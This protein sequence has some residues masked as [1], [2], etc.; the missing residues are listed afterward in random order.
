M[1]VCVLLRH[2][3]SSANEAGVLAGWAPGIGLT[4]T[5]MEQARQVGHQLVGVAL[6]EI[7]TSPVQRAVET[8]RGVA[9]MLTGVALSRDEQLGECH[10][11]AWTGRSLQELAVEPLWRTVQEAPEQAAFPPDPS[12]RYRAESLAEMGIRFE[13]AVRRIDAGVDVVHGPDAVW[14]AVTHGDPIKSLLAA[15]GGAGIEALQKHH[16]DPGALSV[17]RFTPRGS[18]VLAANCRTLD[19]AGLVVATRGTSGDV[20]VGGGDG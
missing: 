18:V 9:E 1:A 5:G 14:L 12:G 15:A 8:A 10:Y 16:V 19:V 6:V 17:I 7:V 11:G 3:Q 2:G 20:A 13:A 4:I